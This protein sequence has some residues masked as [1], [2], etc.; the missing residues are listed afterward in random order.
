MD[1]RTRLTADPCFPHTEVRPTTH[2]PLRGQAMPSKILLHLEAAPLQELLL[3]LWPTSYTV[4]NGKMS[5]N[6]TGKEQKHS[7]GYGK[8][9]EL[10]R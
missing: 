5:P 9:S 7:T 10:Q 3:T 1:P 4:S 2:L 8:W 6:G